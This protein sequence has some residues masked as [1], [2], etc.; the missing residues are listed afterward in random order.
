METSFVETMRGR[1]R[2]A[3]GRESWVDFQIR[4]HGVGGQ[5]TLEGVV[6]APPWTT[7]SPCEGTLVIS[8]WPASIAYD[9]RFRVGGEQYRLHGAK[10]P[11]LL[12][13][14]RSMTVLPITLSRGEEQL[15]QG[16]MTFDLLDLPQF[17]ASWL[18]LPTT[19]RRRFEARHAAVARR[20]LLG[21]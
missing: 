1:L 2:D 6:H 19:A 14:V 16:T 15:A 20:A 11:S 21:D 8:P 9:V 13:P 5:L 10:S 18:P 4:T 12:H 3:A 7:E 17:L